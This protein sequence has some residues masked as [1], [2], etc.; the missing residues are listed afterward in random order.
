MFVKLYYRNYSGG[1]GSYVGQLWFTA[2][3]SL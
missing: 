2:F 3:G 1:R